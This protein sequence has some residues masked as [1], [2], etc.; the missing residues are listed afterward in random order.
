PL[1]A[2]SQDRH[3]LAR[4]AEKGIVNVWRVDAPGQAASVLPA[5]GSPVMQ[6]SFSPDGA[7][8]AAGH[9]YQGKRSTATVWRLG[10]KP[11]ASGVIEF[12]AAV[13]AMV[14]SPNGVTLAAGCNDHTI[15]LWNSDN[16]RLE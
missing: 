2:M 1:W 5:T 3:W 6:L 4:G 8:L 15:Q 16:Q 14:W 9:T 11:Q 7:R 12:R 10:E 13:N